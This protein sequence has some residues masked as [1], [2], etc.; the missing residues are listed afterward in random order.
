MIDLAIKDQIVNLIEDM[1][2]GSYIQTLRVID[3]ITLNQ[4]RVGEY[5]K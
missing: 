3:K 1:N 5:N 2:E 4:L